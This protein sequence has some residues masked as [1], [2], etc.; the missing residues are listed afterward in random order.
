MEMPG[1][2]RSD[3]MHRFGRQRVTF[4][5]DHLLEV[6]DERADRV[7]EL[8]AQLGLPRATLDGPAGAP[9]RAAQQ[10]P[11]RKFADP[12]PSTI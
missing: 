5:H 4:Q 6:F 11:R 10:P 9:A 12:D 8:A 1:L 7:A 2:R 3:P